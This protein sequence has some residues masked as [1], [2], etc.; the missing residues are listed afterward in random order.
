MFD[1]LPWSVAMP[2]VVKRLTCS[3][4]RMPSRTAR[5]MS[6]AVTS[7]W[8]S[9]NALTVVSAP[10]PGAAPTMP[11]A[12]LSDVSALSFMAL[13]GLA[14]GF[15]R[16][17]LA[18]G[19][20]LGDC[21]GEAIGAVRR[22][23]RDAVLRVL[24]G[25]EALR[26]IVEGDLAARLREHVH[27]RR[28]AGRHQDRVDRDR[29]LRPAAL[30]L[31][32]HRRHAQLAAGAN[33]GAAMVDLDA[34]RARLVDRRAGRVVANVDDR[35]D[36]DAGPLQVDRRRIGGIVGRVDADIFSDGDAIMVEIDARGRG[37]HDAWP[38]IVGEHHVA[39]DGA[40]RD[41]HA[42]GAD[43]PQPLARQVMAGLGEMVADPLDQRRRNSARS[44]RTPW[45]AAARAHCPSR[46]AWR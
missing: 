45:C 7:F 4:E 42:L 33:D 12:Q 26:R 41:H 46:Q 2:L 39:L 31:H 38:V 43:L 24:A 29:A 9:T 22:A 30:G 37:K 3:I 20:R 10:A 16:R 34:E 35:R 44:S 6:L 28:P 1:V 15:V 18:G 19:D 14:A 32:G 21:L 25:Q 23:D 13:A 36:I 11:P 5:R 17:L 8:K 27:R 40:G